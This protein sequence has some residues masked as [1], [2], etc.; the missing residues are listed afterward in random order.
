[1]K[2]KQNQADRILAVFGG[3][4]PTAA[5]TGAPVSTVQGWKEAGRIA[6]AWQD[7]VLRASAKLGLGLTPA[8]FFEPATVKALGPIWA[9]A[10]CGAVNPAGAIVCR[11]CDEP[12]AARKA[13][14]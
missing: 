1:M 7:R 8:D 14:A 12:K 9:C 6:C 3:I 2:T 10:H 13:A 11:E 5:K 4:R